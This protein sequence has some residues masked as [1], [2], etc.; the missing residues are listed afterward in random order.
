MNDTPASADIKEIS[1]IILSMGAGYGPVTVFNDFVTL[2]ALSIQ[3]A[4][5]LAG[6]KTWERREDQFLQIIGK[7]SAEAREKF[8]ELFGRLTL[9]IENNPSDVLGSIF[10][11]IGASCGGLG[12]FLP[13]FISQNFAPP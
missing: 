11:E 7:Y 5:C 2:S 9:A 8:P 4:C 1:K 10:M 3:N 6:T 13:R 12:Q